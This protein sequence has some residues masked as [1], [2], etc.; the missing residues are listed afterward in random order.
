[1]EKKA[2]RK[3][4]QEIAG[5]TE[6]AARTAART[7]EENHSETEGVLMDERLKTIA[8]HYGLGPQLNILQEELAELIQAVSKYRRGDP[9]HI[10]E[11]LA[12]VYVM[13]DQIT[14]LLQQTTN[15]DLGELI[16]LH[17]EKKIRR[18]LRR[19]EEELE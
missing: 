12:D 9:S 18:Q 6:K 11:E 14:Y 13:L 4:Q 17:A 5:D 16:S 3:G 1:M 10:I 15:V 2:R 8:D 19:I 7:E